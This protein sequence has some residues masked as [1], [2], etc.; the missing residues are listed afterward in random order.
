MCSKY[1]Y[2][3]ELDRL[4]SPVIIMFLFSNFKLL[5]IVSNESLSAYSL[6]C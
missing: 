4:K 5:K 1:E 2:A 3:L 6:A